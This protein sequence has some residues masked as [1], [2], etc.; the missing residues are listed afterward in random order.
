MCPV[1]AVRIGGFAVRIYTFSRYEIRS[2]GVESPIV[3]AH[4][5]DAR[6]EMHI[7]TTYESANRCRG[8]KEN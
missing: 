4:N 2:F 8:K 5:H 6:R 3:L 1:N 7:V